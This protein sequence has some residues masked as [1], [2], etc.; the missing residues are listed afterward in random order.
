MPLLEFLKPG[1]MTSIQDLGRKGGRFYAIP[2]S[3]AMDENAARIAQLLLNGSPDMPLIECTGLPPTIRFHGAGRIALSGADF[4]WTINGRNL[5][6]PCVISVE[7]GDVLEGKHAREQM[8]GYIAVAGKWMEPPV[9]GSFSTYVNG[10]FGGY[11]G[12]MI[13]KGDKIE[14]RSGGAEEN[15]FPV[16]P[17]RRGPEFEFLLEADALKS[18]FE[19]GAESN[20]MG[21]RLKG[22]VVHLRTT[23]LIDSVPVLPGFI[24]VPPDGQPIVVLQ[25]GQVTGGY[26]RVAYIPEAF[27]PVFNQIP[28]GKRFRFSLD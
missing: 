11:Q 6:V 1:L 15:E 26:P 14:W 5:K 13:R 19:V 17:L 2:A 10:K 22:P 27:L 28:L 16:I 3:G 8:R 18:V 4:N 25:D 20:R 9:Y 21:A 12:R 24:Q 23:H 7:N